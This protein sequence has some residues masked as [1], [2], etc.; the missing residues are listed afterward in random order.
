[1]AKNPNP[2]LIF[3]F[4]I[5]EVEGEGQ[6]LARQGEVLAREW[7]QLFNYFTVTPCINQIH[8]ASRFHEDIP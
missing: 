6:G 7:K 8:I 4:Y 2:G 1:M 5:C 3:L